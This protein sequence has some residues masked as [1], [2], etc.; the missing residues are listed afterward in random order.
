[1]GRAIAPVLALLYVS[2]LASGAVWA[3]E[4]V[5]LFFDGFDGEELGRDWGP[6]WAGTGTWT[7]R[8]GY[9]FLNMSD[10][11]TGP[12]RSVA[13]LAA[14]QKRIYCGFEVRLRCSDDNKRESGT[15]GGWRSWGL[16]ESA[17]NYIAFQSVS[18]ESRSQWVG[19]YAVQRANASPV[20][21]QPIPAV[22][23]TEWHDYAII[24]KPDNTT[25]LVDGEVV[26]AID[27]S[28][29]VGLIPVIEL[30]NLVLHESPGEPPWSVEHIDVPFNVSI[31][32]DYAHVVG[33]IPE[34]G[35]LPSLVLILL[36][37]LP[38]GLCRLMTHDRT[39]SPLPS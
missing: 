37:S 15:G 22:D 30:S 33:I 28:P 24:W 36:P 11:T 5:T 10:N 21:S 25:F 16:V 34:L 32:L 1:M 27:K 4:Y 26:A 12:E 29:S 18:P 2:M 20:F 23:M 14:P 7:L 13:L 35:L 31:Q 38:L 9:L 17:A 8:D 19:F 39:N 3:D 6:E